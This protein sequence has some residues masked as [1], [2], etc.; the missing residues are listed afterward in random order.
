MFYDI[1]FGSD[2]LDMTPKAQ[3]TE[4]KKNRLDF[5][6][7]LKI[8]ALK[9]TIHRGRRQPT[10]WEKIFANHVSDKRLMISRI[11]R[12]LLKFNSNNKINFKMDLNRH[13]SREDTHMF[14]KHMKDVQYH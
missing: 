12:E 9:D 1:G 3:A 2:F 5:M 10:E 14:R 13:F 6:K 11:Y 7:I 8:C 4:N